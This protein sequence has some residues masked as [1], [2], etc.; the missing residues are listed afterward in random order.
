V[1]HADADLRMPPKKKLGDTEIALLMDWVRSGASDPRESSVPSKRGVK[2]E[3]G[4]NHW[5]FQPPKQREAKASSPDAPNVSAIDRFIFEKLAVQGLRPSPRADART[6]IRRASYDLLGL[7]PTF[8]ETEAFVAASEEN[9]DR[10]F[11]SLV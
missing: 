8:G 9:P 4:R 3:E 7:P 5:S 10:A 6:L 1:R 2:M 11:S